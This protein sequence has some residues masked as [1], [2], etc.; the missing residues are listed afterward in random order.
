MSQSKIKVL[1]A[2]DSSFMR[3]VLSD[4][5][6]SDQELSIVSTAENGKE[7]FEM[8]VKFKPDV[9]LLDLLM[10]DYDGLYAV[11][12]IMKECP[13]PI[14]ILS[15]SASQDSALVFEALEAGAYDFLGKPKGTF[16]SKIRDIEATVI[17]KIKNAASINTSGLSKKNTTANTH[18]HTFEKNLLYDIVVIGSS[19]G[20]TAAIDEILK[21]LPI[22]FPIPVVIAQHMPRE[23][24]DSFAKRLNEM[25]P[26]VVKVAEDGET[27]KG[28]TV[29][30]T[31]G[32]LNTAIVRNKPTS[33]ATIKFTD[34]KFAEYNYPSVNCLF[35]SA[36]E[37][38]K[39]KSLAIILSGM[40]RDGTEG[41]KDLFGQD[42][43]TIAQDEKSSVVFGMPKSVIEKGLVKQVL[44]MYEMGGYIVSCLS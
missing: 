32:H 20:G 44:S 9:L 35:S 31:P 19:T 28:G 42:A 43:F 10:P 12:C 37:V 40:G 8:T 39:G 25:L 13:T 22:N 1:I 36:A 15:G 17:S 4:M 14:I 2:D 18:S 11:K 27:L 38:Y 29:Y 21:K 30:L 6:N 3:L 41:M 5:I 23:F 34:E 16:G 26:L 7:A 24:I 33:K